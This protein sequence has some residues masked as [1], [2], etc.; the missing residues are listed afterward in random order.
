MMPARVAS[1]ESMKAVM[2]YKQKKITDI[3]QLNQQKKHIV[4]DLCI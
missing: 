4:D 1:N 3:E 2:S